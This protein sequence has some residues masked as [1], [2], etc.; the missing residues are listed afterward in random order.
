MPTCRVGAKIDRRPQVRVS[1]DARATPVKIIDRAGLG[2][3]TSASANTVPLSSRRL[4]FPRQIKS[5]RR[6]RRRRRRRLYGET[7]FSVGRSVG[8]A[9]ANSRPSRRP[10]ANPRDLLPR[11][12]KKFFFFYCQSRA[13][14]ATTGRTDA[15][16]KFSAHSVG[17]TRASVGCESREGN[18]RA[19]R[20]GA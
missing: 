4:I 20:S 9:R 14:A 16:V 13:T 10:T 1:G 5:F 8:V 11:R 17:R 2:V 15:R 3:P 19:E 7:E 12:R 6:R 18:S